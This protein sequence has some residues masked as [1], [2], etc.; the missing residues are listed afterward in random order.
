MTIQTYGEYLN[1]NPHLHAL[2]ADGLFTDVVLSA[3]FPP[4]YELGRN[5][6]H[7]TGW[8]ENRPEVMGS[9]LFMRTIYLPPGI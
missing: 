3:I 1:A 8:N 7:S 5:K 4:V 9:E 2:V 6:S